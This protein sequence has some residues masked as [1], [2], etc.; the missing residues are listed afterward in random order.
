MKKFTE[1]WLSTPIKLALAAVERLKKLIS[2][3]KSL[4]MVALPALA[5]LVKCM[6]PSS[7][8]KNLCVMPELFVI[9]I[10]LRVSVRP[11]FTAI[12]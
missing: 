9:P 7:P 3:P 6:C 5:L 1:V 2:L 11:E 8:T 12:V 10:P 4:K